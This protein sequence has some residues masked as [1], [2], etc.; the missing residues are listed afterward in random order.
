MTHRF[1][2]LQ[3]NQMLNYLIKDNSNMADDKKNNMLLLLFS[4]YSQRYFVGDTLGITIVKIQ[5]N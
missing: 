5:V 3:R 4:Q 1:L 2:L